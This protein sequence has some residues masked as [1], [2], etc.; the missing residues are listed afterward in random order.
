MA[1]F[2]KPDGTFVLRGECP[3]CGRAA[4]FVTKT[5][6]YKYTTNDGFFTTEVWVAGL[7][8]A[9]CSQFILGIVGP[10]SFGNGMSY[11]AH[12]PL[13]KPHQETAEAI[14]QNII[15]DY[16]E[17]LRCKSV[18][19]YNATAEMCRRA[20]ESSCL[21]LGADPKL[22]LDKK[23]DWLASEGKIIASLKDMAHKVRLGGNR[24]AHPPDDPSEESPL[25][26]EEAEALVA[27]TWKYLEAIYVTPAEL[28]K[29][30]FSRSRRSADLRLL[31]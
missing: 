17:A 16:N 4:V 27:F 11:I 19:A 2:N 18:D 24:G 5:S 30:D 31:R 25:G 1:S 26:P 21:S 6:S 7:Q 8:C 28:G 20:L 12:Y 14:P 29:F 10:S 23:I 3:H 13:G 9:G 15:D 22:P